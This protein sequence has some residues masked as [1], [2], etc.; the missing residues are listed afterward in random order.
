MDHHEGHQASDTRNLA[1]K[2][3]RVAGIIKYSQTKT[4]PDTD[5]LKFVQPQDA[6]VLILLQPQDATWRG[7]IMIFRRF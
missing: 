6:E 7:K 1:P 2:V 4:A 3:R 5:V